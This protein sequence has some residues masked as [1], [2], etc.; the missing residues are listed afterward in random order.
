[1]SKRYIPMGLMSRFC[2]LN[3]K[4]KVNK[5]SLTQNR[6]QMQDALLK[7]KMKSLIVNYMLTVNDLFSGD[8]RK[9]ISICVLLGGEHH[10]N[11]TTEPQRMA[12]TERKDTLKK[13][14]CCFQSLQ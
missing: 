6:F 7:L 8:V 5:G 13:D 1:M 2:S 10:D 11:S 3:M 4:Q 12:L 14:V 9:N